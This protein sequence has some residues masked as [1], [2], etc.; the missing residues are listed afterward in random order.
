MG[1]NPGMATYGYIRVST[2]EQALGLEAQRSAILAKYPD[3]VIEADEG[4]SG[5]NP[6]RPA[7]LRII[8]SLNPGDTVV[9]VRRDRLARDAFLAMMFDRDIKRRKARLWSLAEGVSDDSDPMSVLQSGLGD[10]FAQY[11]RAMIRARTRAALKAKRERGELYASVPYGYRVVDGKRLEP[12][13][14]EQRIVA[15]AWEL[16]EKGLTLRAIAAALGAAGHRNRRGGMFSPQTIANMLRGP[17]HREGQ[18]AQ[19]V[20]A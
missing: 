2:D 20:A 15:T 1:L 8:N 6:D 14:A 11:E 16:R 18:A 5:A 17:R 12:N 7:L 19:P 4:V 10:L 13:P 3:A 9:V